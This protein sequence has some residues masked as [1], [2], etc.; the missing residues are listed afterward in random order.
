MEIA[1]VLEASRDI[2]LADAIKGDARNDCACRGLNWPADH[3]TPRVG[4]LLAASCSHSMRVP[5]SAVWGRMAARTCKRCDQIV[6]LRD[7]DGP[8]GPLAHTRTASSS[9]TTWRCM[10]CFG[11]PEP[12][13]EL[14]MTVPARFPY[15]LTRQPLSNL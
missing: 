14:S 2:C 11:G 3:P 10:P 15:S 7:D 9:T 5:A 1:A 13:K 12:A 8:P 6:E 4:T